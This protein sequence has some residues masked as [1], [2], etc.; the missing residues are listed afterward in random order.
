MSDEPP[1]SWCIDGDRIRVRRVSGDRLDVTSMEIALAEFEG[2]RVF[3]RFAVSN[4]PSS[5]IPSVRFS[6]YPKRLEVRVIEPRAGRTG[7]ATIAFWYDGHCVFDTG[8]IADALRTDHFVMDGLWQMVAPGQ[9][10]QLME[11]LPALNLRDLGRLTLGSYL[12]L[13]RAEPEYVVFVKPPAFPSE[14]PQTPDEA[15]SVPTG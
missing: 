14:P 5:D 13:R 3:E 11:I 9:T 10:D 12:A 6:P 4:A 1:G 8:S 2:Q 7:G 15:A